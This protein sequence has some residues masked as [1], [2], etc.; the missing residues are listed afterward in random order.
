MLLV[1]YGAPLR[2]TLCVKQKT[3]LKTLHNACV[4]FTHGGIP[5]RGSVTPYRLGL[6]WLS[7]NTRRKY[8]AVTL[9]VTVLKM[10]CL[11]ER[12]EIDPGAEF[13]WC[14]PRYPRPPLACPLFSKLICE[15]SFII[16]TPMAINKLALI[17]YNSPVPDTFKSTLKAILFTRNCNELIARS[18]I[19]DLELL[20]LST[21]NAL[22]HF[23]HI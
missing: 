20:A 12:Y 23:L 17:F 11:L 21:R 2:T 4:R 18:Q 14:L 22:S 15:N 16:Q 13:L 19:K 8:L 1:D 7:S 5:R 9:A 10:S 3:A 6:S